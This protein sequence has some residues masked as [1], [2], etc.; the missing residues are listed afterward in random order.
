[1]GLSGVFDDRSLRTKIGTAVLTAVVSGL[2]VG[3]LALTTVYHQNNDSAAAQRRTIAVEEASGAFGKNIE[4]YG[5]SIS[6]L[7]LYPT[8]KASL[9]E[10][11]K[12]EESAITGALGRLQS[13]LSSDRAGAAEVT[14]AQNDWQAFQAFMNSPAITGQATTAAQLADIVKQ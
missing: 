10:G 14:K 3:G 13:S 4:A 5:G 11:M 8:L 9:L 12:A 6:A 7:K 2:A 1:M